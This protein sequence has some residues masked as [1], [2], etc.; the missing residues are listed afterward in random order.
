[1]YHVPRLPTSFYE[2]LHLVF[3]FG[4]YV[5]NVIAAQSAIGAVFLLK[6][7]TLQHTRARLLR[8]RN[9]SFIASN[10][11]VWGEDC[12]VSLNALPKSETSTGPTGHHH[13]LIRQ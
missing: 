2:S 10:S 5:A 13:G 12:L 8:R 3:H 4:G 6:G 9:A 11:H 7:V 1:M